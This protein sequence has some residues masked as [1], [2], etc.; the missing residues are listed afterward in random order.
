MKTDYAELLPKDFASD[1]RVWIYQSDRKFAPAEENSINKIL[2]NFSSDW[3]SHGTPVKGFGRILN[4]QFIVLIADESATGV[5]GCST[6]SSVRL[7]KELEQRVNLKL[8]DWQSLAFWLRGDCAGTLPG[9]QAAID[10]GFI[11]FDTPFFSNTM[12]DLRALKTDWLVLP[13]KPG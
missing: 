3:H 5:S 13:G 11:Q 10:D 7:I 8:F 6:D 1:S 12:A 2:E 4:S 9:L